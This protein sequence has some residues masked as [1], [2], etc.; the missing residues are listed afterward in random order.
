MRN[1]LR[2]RT[3]NGLLV[4]GSFSYKTSSIVKWMLKSIELNSSAMFYTARQLDNNKPYFCLLGKLL[5]ISLFKYLRSNNQG[6]N[7]NCQL[8]KSKKIG[9][10]LAGANWQ[11]VTPNFSLP[12]CP[13]EKKIRFFGLRNFRHAPNQTNLSCQIVSWE[14]T[15]WLS[16]NYWGP[17][18]HAVRE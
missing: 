16:D 17:W 10:F 7:C 9:T 11:G 3:K 2:S 12:G 8:W 13:G 5:G 15:P 6:W 18:E 4:S 1:W 14:K